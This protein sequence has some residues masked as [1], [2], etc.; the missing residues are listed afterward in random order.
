VWAIY[1]SKPLDLGP[2]RGEG[3][4]DAGRLISTRGLDERGKKK[5]QKKVRCGGFLGVTMTKELSLK[6]GRGRTA[7]ELMGKLQWGIKNPGRDSPENSLKSERGVT[8]GGCVPGNIRA[9]KVRKAHKT[10]GEKGTKKRLGARGKGLGTPKTFRGKR[11][12]RVQ[13]KIGRNTTLQKNSNFA[14]GPVP[15]PRETPIYGTN[16]IVFQNTRTIGGGIQPL[17]AGKC[18]NIS[19]LRKCLSGVVARKF[20]GARGKEEEPFRGEEAPTVFFV[21]WYFTNAKRK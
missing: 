11:K 1:K 12:E 20:N 10:Y 15:F 4:L 18:E 17:S 21:G 8:L 13:K 2:G 5:P 3:R 6:A 14:L 7:L 19:K 9:Y 16:S